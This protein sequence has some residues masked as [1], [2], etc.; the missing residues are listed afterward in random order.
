MKTSHTRR[1]F[2]RTSAI[3]A[4]GTVAGCKTTGTT[5]E[6]PVAKP[7]A[8]PTVVGANERLTVGFI[9]VGGQGFNAHVGNVVEFGGEQ[10]VVGAAVCDVWSKRR[11][12]ALEAL[13]LDESNGYSDYRALLDRDD[14]DAVFIGTV[15]HW[16][17][18]ISVAAL[19]AGKHVYCEKPMTRYLEEAFDVL[20]AVERT[21]LVF[22]MGSQYT[23]EAK[24]HKAAELVQ[25]GMIGPPVLAQ[26]SFTRNIP[27]GEWNYEIDPECTPEACDW[28]TWLGAVSDRPFSADEYFRWRKYYP[29]CAGILGDLLAHRI[30]PLLVATGNPEYPSKVV[31]LGTRQVTPDRDV[32]DQQ[33]LIAE[34]PS[35]LSFM[36]MGS[37]VNEQGFDE[38]FRGHEATMYMGS[39]VLELRPERPF[40]DLIDRQMFDD[41]QPGPSVPHHMANFYDAVR[42]DV[43]PN[44]NID[45]AVKT[46]TI[47]SLAEMSE[48]LGEMMHF[49]AET[50]TVSA[51]SGRKIEPI[52][53]G[54]LELS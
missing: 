34:F 14:V 46:Q 26:N 35:G 33:Q 30:A 15:D 20:Q 18:R 12:Q 21:G 53:Y 7:T 24:W 45:I 44:A 27:E 41:L 37:T 23:T 52:T 48:R 32:P 13:E 31:C 28:S 9:G 17:S 29:Y 40:A 3:V 2:L 39:N 4:T 25:A 43:E 36:V 1:D 49:D 54:T 38:V 51:G 47:I 5:V 11:E 50:R 22:Q 16:H 10:N 6:E 19:D 8:P 42:T